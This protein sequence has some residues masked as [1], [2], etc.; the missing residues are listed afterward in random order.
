MSLKKRASKE[1]I[2]VFRCDNKEKEKKLQ[3]MTM[4]VA[5]DNQERHRRISK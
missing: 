2:E 1:S 5:T 3:S 4:E